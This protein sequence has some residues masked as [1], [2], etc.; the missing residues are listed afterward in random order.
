MIN[1]RFHFFVTPRPI[2]LF[3]TIYIPP[4]T[5]T[6][7]IKRIIELGY[8]PIVDSSRDCSREFALSAP[9]SLLWIE[10]NGK[11]IEPKDYIS[12]RIFLIIYWPEKI[13][14]QQYI[15]A[16]FYFG[17][18]LD[19]QEAA[20]GLLTRS[21]SRLLDGD[22]F[23][24]TGGNKCIGGSGLLEYTKLSNGFQQITTVQGGIFE[25]E[26]DETID[27]AKGKLYL[28]TENKNVDYKRIKTSYK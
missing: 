22:L 4:K 5:E 15:A 19:M 1:T 21:V 16:S 28:L 17:K 23:K 18:L 20:K 9:Q 11:F 12:G 26:V 2:S 10:G 8:A 3:D 6:D 24:S 7:I 25:K 14:S 13:S 27:R